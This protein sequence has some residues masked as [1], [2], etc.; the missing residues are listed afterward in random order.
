MEG[1]NPDN[2]VLKKY[3]QEVQSE[4]LPLPRFGHTV[5]LI[6]KASIVIFG[7]EISMPDNQQTKLYY[8]FRFIFI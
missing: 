6:S 1:S 3:A 4:K 2:K 7:G 5:N 8:D